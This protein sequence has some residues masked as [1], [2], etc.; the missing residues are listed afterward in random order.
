MDEKEMEM[1]K[2][3]KEEQL[4]LVQGMDIMQRL[5]KASRSK[6][7]HSVKNFFEIYISNND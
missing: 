5:D 2:R 4:A 6:I 7:L 1:Q 3:L